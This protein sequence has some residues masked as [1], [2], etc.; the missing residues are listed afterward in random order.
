MD[1]LGQGRC[2][3]RQRE[4]SVSAVARGADWDRRVV[5]CAYREQGNRDRKAR[6]AD[7]PH[8]YAASSH[9]LVSRNEEVGKEGRLIVPR[10]SFLF[11]LFN[12]VLSNSFS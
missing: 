10:A 5:A 9:A 8:C 12:P 6:D 11:M 4:S 2:G 3:A 1:V 7:T